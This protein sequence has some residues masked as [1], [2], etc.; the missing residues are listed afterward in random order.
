MLLSITLCSGVV[1]PRGSTSDES[2]SKPA[3]IHSR[4]GN[5]IFIP[6]KRKAWSGKREI[7]K[8]A[9]LSLSIRYC[10]RQ[11]V[12][13]Y[14][15]QVDYSSATVDLIQCF[16]PEHL[17]ENVLKN[18]MGTSPWNGVMRVVLPVG[19]EDGDWHI[20]PDINTDC[21]SN[22]YIHNN[23][24]NNDNSNSTSKRNNTIQYTEVNTTSSIALGDETMSYIVQVG[25]QL[26]YGSITRMPFI[27]TCVLHKQNGDN[28]SK[29]LE[30]LTSL[31]RCD[32][33]KHL[34][35]LFSGYECSH[36]PLATMVAYFKAAWFLAKFNYGLI[37][38]TILCVLLP[39]TRNRLT[40]NSVHSRQSVYA[41]II[42]NAVWMI[43]RLQETLHWDTKWQNHVPYICVAT[44]T[45]RYMVEGVALFLF[46]CT[47]LERYQVIAGSLLSYVSGKKV[48]LATVASSVGFVIG[49]FC[50]ILNIVALYMMGKS[51]SMLKT[52]SVPHN[53]SMSLMPLIVVKVVSLVAMYLVPCS[54]MATANCAMSSIVRRRTSQNLGRCYSKKQKD[55]SKKTNMISSFLV[56]SS[57]F[58]VCCMSKPLYELYVAIKIWINGSVDA[59]QGSVLLDA[60]TWNLTTIAYTINTVLGLRYTKH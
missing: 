40:R 59:E 35:L 24:N 54:T 20:E 53:V 38:S 56:F 15:F 50:S 45:I 1:L 30:H 11:N 2:S 21:N 7:N 32:S 46:A 39:N 26:D 17:E 14:W 42:A 10:L 34:L 49:L 16:H 28:S 12:T 41:F 51:S 37:L 29:I 27:S 31:A 52:C 57:V 6:W 22:K 43:W 48:K 55:S 19:P 58:M 44:N 13:M 9:G 3:A 47:S 25:C 36:S 5:K 4:N 60:I 18:F 23:T 33:Q 8:T